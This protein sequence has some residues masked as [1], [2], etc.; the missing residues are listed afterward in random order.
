[1]GI[2]RRNIWRKN[3]ILTGWMQVILFVP[4]I[5]AAL[6]IIF[7]QEC[8]NLLNINN[9]LYVI[10]IA[11]GVIVF[12]AVLNSLGAKFGGAISNYIYFM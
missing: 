10:A 6:G 9:N 2:F 1:M 7:A 12:I 8:A 11:I 5:V 4:A 3:R